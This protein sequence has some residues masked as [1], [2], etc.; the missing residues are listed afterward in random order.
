MAR[1]EEAAR[2]VEDR[3]RRTLRASAMRVLLS[4]RAKHPDDLQDKL[5]RGRRD[6]KKRDRYLFGA[7]DKDLNSVVT[8]L[9]G[10]RVMVYRFSDVEKAA[11]AVRESFPLANVDNVF[12][13]HDKPTGYRAIHI[14]VQIPLN[15]ER[16]SLRGTIVEVQVTSLPAH[17]FNE[18]DHD[19][20]YKDHGSKPGP[21]EE[22][23]LKEVRW[24]TWLL[25][26]SVE[27]LMEERASAVKELEDAVELRFVLE[28]EARRPLYGEFTRLF[29]LLFAVERK[30]TLSVITKLGTVEDLLKRGEEMAGE[31]GV[32][33]DDVVHLA[34]ALFEH[35]P[36]ELE[37]I[38]R[39]WRGPP[40]HLKKAIEAASR[41]RKRGK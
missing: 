3:L 40:T 32:E 10:C 15:A 26:R 31:L 17:V 20:K 22:D 11:S 37:E 39:A 34:L 8:D 2:L 19:I 30:V 5:Y 16:M 41:T 7:L 21:R 9:A 23:A 6:P 25:D 12:E 28:K 35:F 33:T 13:P 24:G 36:S 29:R 1:Y 38:V 4:S 14:L 18:L 27:R